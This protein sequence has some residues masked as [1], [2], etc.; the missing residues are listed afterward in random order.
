MV[1]YTSS[2]IAFGSSFLPL[3]LDDEEESSVRESITGELRNVIGLRMWLLMLARFM[4]SYSRG[5]VVAFL[6]IMAFIQL[7]IS[8]EVIMLMFSLGGVC[9]MLGR[10]V[11]ASQPF[12][13]SYREFLIVGGLS[14]ALAVGLFSL[15]NPYL[16]WLGMV[17]YGLAEGIFAPSSIVYT[18]LLVPNHARTMGMALLGLMVDTGMIVGNMGSGSLVDFIGF[19]GIFLIGMIIALAGVGVV[20][21]SLN[22]KK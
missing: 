20:T 17:F 11:T 12:R 3:L 4:T 18:S 8:E 15:S 2:A 21:V 1:F 19:N 22:I 13:M 9:N 5:M 7:G 14:M 16:I 6:P 10:I